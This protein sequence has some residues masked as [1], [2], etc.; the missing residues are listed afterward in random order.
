MRFAIMCRFDGQED[1]TDLFDADA[2]EDAR[3]IAIRAAMRP[4]CT[5]Y[6][7]DGKLRERVMDF[8]DEKHR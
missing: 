8:D 2:I 6:V 4:G 5:V 3:Q 1:F 7:Y